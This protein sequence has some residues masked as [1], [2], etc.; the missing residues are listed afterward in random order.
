MN[1]T[2]LEPLSRCLCSECQ[3]DPYSR[4]A[5]QHRAINRLVISLDE[6][7]RRLVVGFLAQQYGRGG[8]ARLMTITGMSRDTIRRGQRELVN[9]A[10]AGSRGGVL[11]AN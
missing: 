5:E 4:V 8:I 2:T 11:R 9:P 10:P 7:C 3:L 6:R 1:R